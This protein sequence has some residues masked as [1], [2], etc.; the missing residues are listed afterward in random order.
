MGAGGRSAQ[1]EEPGWQDFGK[2][3]V[4]NLTKAI[5]VFWKR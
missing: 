5:D 1:G 2:D 4:G 3:V